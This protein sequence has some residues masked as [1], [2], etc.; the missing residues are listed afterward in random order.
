M[1]EM[2]LAAVRVEFNDLYG[3]AIPAFNETWHNKGLTLHTVA[4]R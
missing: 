4:S 3:K 2:H 1:V